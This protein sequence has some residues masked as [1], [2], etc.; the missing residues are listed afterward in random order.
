MKNDLS[1][2]KKIIQECIKTKNTYLD[3]GNCGITNLSDL[4][5]LFECTQVETLILSSQWFD[6][7]ENKIIHSKNNGIRNNI[8]I[9]SSNIEKL[10]SL[11]TLRIGGS[12]YF[13]KFSFVY[14]Y[15]NISDISFLEKLTQLQSL[16]LS[17]NQISFIPE[18]VFKLDNWKRIVDEIIDNNPISN[19]PIEKIKQ[20]RESV[21]DWFA[22]TREKFNEIKIILIGEPKAGKTSLL[23]RLKNNDFDEEEPQTDGINIVD[24][25]FGKAET[26]QNQKKLHNIKGRFWDFGGQEIMSATHKLFLS[27]RSVYILLL[28]ARKDKGTEK[29][30]RDWVNEIIVTGGNSPIIVVANKIEINSSNFCFFCP[31]IT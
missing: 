17:S 13:Y 4:P 22:A 10:K 14:D 3:L 24:I 21:L 9:L 20:G 19:P 30:V 18:F 15:W 28:G 31:Q 11:S 12:F 5:E 7:K 25:D 2:A 29:Q 16:D 8:K 26:F 27:N 23:K 1:Q 6:N